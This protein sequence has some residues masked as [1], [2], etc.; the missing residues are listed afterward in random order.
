MQKINPTLQLKN[1]ILLLEV[2]QAIAEQQLKAQFHKTYESLKPINLIKSTL[3]N[4]VST[5]F[6]I[7]SIL[8]TVVG[9]ASGYVSKKI[10]VGASA[11]IIR[12]LLGSIMQF[13]VTN[14]V[15]KHSGEIKT[16]GEFLIHKILHK[17]S[18][19]TKS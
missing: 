14:V 19:T 9:L 4:V 15:A 10:V 3:N 5:P 12:K 8:G 18:N 17:K 16:I 1:A 7:D 13:G 11:N 2:D 6:S